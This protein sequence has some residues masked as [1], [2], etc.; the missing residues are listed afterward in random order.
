MAGEQK[1]HLSKSSAEMHEHVLFWI[2][3][4]DVLAFQRSRRD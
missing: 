4:F 1:D 2:P 3:F